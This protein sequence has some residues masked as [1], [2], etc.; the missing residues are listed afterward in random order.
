MEKTCVYKNKD[1]YLCMP[2]SQIAIQKE[3]KPILEEI[4]VFFKQLNDENI[5]SIYLRGSLVNG[6]GI[7]NISDVDL[8]IIIL[9]PLSEINLKKISEYFYNLNKKYPFVSKFDL[10]YFLLNKIFSAK[11]N[12]LIKLNGVC[13]YGE[14]IKNKIS[15]PR[16]GKDITISLSL[17]ER[18]L[19]KTKKEIE[20]GFYNEL[21]TPAMCLWIMKRIVRSGLEMVSERE[22]CFTRDLSACLDK[23]SKYYPDK[24]ENLNKAFLLAI[25]P[26]KDLNLIKNIFQDIGNWLICEAKRLNL[27]PLNCSEISELILQKISSLFEKER[28]ICIL[29][30]GPKKTYDGS[31]PT[32]FDFLLLLDKY[33][34][35]D[36]IL[37]SKIKELNLPVEIFVDYKDQILSKGIKNY[38]RGRHG[39][40]FFKILSSAETLM[41]NNFYKDNEKEL[42]ID[43][44]NFDLLYR[45][46][47]YF[48][49]IQKAL[50]NKKE[51]DKIQIEKYLGRILT[52][53]MLVNREIDFENVHNYHYTSILLNLINSSQMFNSNTKFLINTF[54]YN[55]NLD[56]DC[57]SKIIGELYPTYLKIRQKFIK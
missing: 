57:L 26:T 32:D 51:F 36:F 48:Y 33:Q 3:Y 11:E 16:P 13:I 5:H 15:D 47:E 8:F 28:I 56:F 52:D 44:I 40:Y 27:I 43:K 9:K 6:L 14:D 4:V 7:K 18:E 46:E 1:G 38:Q 45:V 41:G 34:N 31:P 55:N 22:G 12:V 30:Y 25:K 2:D 50:I 42:N 39:S 53:L 21:N 10:G 20:S 24:K 23:F 17:L 37:L 19:Y 29:R 54:I 49:R 35:R